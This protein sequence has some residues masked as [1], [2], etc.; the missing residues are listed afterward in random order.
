MSGTDAGTGE[1]RAPAP[2]ASTTAATTSSGKRARF[3][4]EPPY[5]SVRVLVLSFR[6]LSSR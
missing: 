3:S 6:K 2:T 1:A 4:T 5:S